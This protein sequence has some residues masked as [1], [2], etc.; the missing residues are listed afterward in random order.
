MVAR[1]SW[2]DSQLGFFNPWNSTECSISSEDNVL[3]TLL[4]KNKT[5][6]DI[7]GLFFDSFPFYVSSFPPTKKQR[8]NGREPKEEGRVKRKKKDIERENPGQADGFLVSVLGH[9]QGTNS[10]TRNKPSQVW[11]RRQLKSALQV[12]LARL[13]A[14]NP[15]KPGK[16]LVVSQSFG[17]FVSVSIPQKKKQTP[18]HRARWKPSENEVETISSLE[19]STSINSLLNR[20]LEKK[21]FVIKLYSQSWCCN[22]QDQTSKVISRS[23]NIISIKNNVHFWLERITKEKA[24]DQ[25]FIHSSFIS[26]LN[27]FQRNSVKTMWFDVVFPP[28]FRMNEIPATTPLEDTSFSFRSLTKGNPWRKRIVFFFWKCFSK[29]SQKLNKVEWTRF[30]RITT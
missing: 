26:K 1:Q 22:N 12:A 7:V 11:Q 6:S 20:N 3:L 10:T 16:A 18:Q 5:T 24:R 8:N 9:R 17:V 30:V 28:L 27:R 23:F 19:T 2:S 25:N 4:L 15:V 21:F 14:E 29:N 13:D